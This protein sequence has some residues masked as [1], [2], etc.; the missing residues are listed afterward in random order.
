MRTDA[1]PEESN[2]ESAVHESDHGASTATTTPAQQDDAAFLESAAPPRVDSNGAR[3][4]IDQ[5]TSDPAPLVKVSSA[6]GDT[7]SYRRPTRTNPVIAVLQSFSIDDRLGRILLS[8]ILAVLLWFYVTSLENPA[9]TFE[10]N[11]LQ[12]DARN[13][14]PNLLLINQASLPSIQVTVQAP[15]NIL[16][17][18]RPGDLH[19]FLDLNDL[20]AGVH[21]VPVNVEATGNVNPALINMTPYPASVQV[22][23]EVRATQIYSVVVQV[24]GT[25][26][27]GSGIEP[28]QVE[29]P[30][31]RVTGTES[32]VARIDKVVVDV[33][34][35]DK[36]STQSGDRTPLALDSSGN[37]IN[38][39]TFEPE[40]VRVTV[41][42]KP[43][44][45]TKV[46]GVNVPIEGNPAPGYSVAE[47]LRDPTTVTIC[48]APTDTLDSIQF[49][50]TEPVSISGT[51]STVVTTTRLIVP[52]GIQLYPGQPSEINVTVR[53]D[54]FE[55]SWQLSVVP[56]VEGA[57]NGMAVVVSPNTLDL[58]LSGTFAQF[59]SLKPTDVRAVVNVGGRGPGTYEIAPQVIVP[60]GIK[61]DSVSPSVLTVSVIAPTAVPPTATLT[62]APTPTNT[63]AP[64]PTP[65]EQAAQVAPTPARSAAPPT[66]TVTAPTP[67]PTPPPTST[68]TPTSPG[69]DGSPS[70][71]GVP[72]PT[73][74][75][76]PGPPLP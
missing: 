38:G 42:I 69:G 19:P 24:N 55:T 46:V 10:F 12:L 28:P 74:E 62:P 66:S 7:G 40:T 53:V 70:T 17:G 18:V 5:L 48:C 60:Q 59:Q 23:L 71:D 44:Y 52:P 25:P 67:Q 3:S 1:S 9:Q 27:L 75:L 58:T 16:S 73:P 61:L 54:T 20:D 15:Q 6:R 63:T 21:Q 11:N 72:N 26:A 65:S 30:Q 51:V 76:T 68:P 50:N 56:T 29:P 35:S 36:T 33:D 64:S 32:A 8:I 47:V 31:V 13:L 14:T 49:L 4:D 43:L 2:P 34:V 37:E 39:L 41:P 57:P 45:E 22:L